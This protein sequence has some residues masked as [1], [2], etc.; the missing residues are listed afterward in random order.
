MLIQIFA[1][2]RLHEL[3]DDLSEIIH[4]KTDFEILEGHKVLEVK[5]VNTIKDKR[6]MLCWQI[7]KFGFILAA[8][9][10]K[11]DEFLFKA[12]PGSACSIRV[13]LN[14][15]FAKYNVTDISVL[16]ELLEGLAE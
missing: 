8:G 1:Q 5:A 15:S 7:K 9:D 12:L 13:G 16:L 11:T 4:H 6:L 10:D 2:L 14:P 3:R